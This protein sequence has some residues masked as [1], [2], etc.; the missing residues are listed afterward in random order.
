MVDV[1]ATV[2]NEA[3]EMDKECEGRTLIQSQSQFDHSQRL[4]QASHR[5]LAQ[6]ETCC[7][8]AFASVGFENT[9]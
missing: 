5:L 4:S 1:L 6:A 3:V 7:Y 8:R 9:S 2:M